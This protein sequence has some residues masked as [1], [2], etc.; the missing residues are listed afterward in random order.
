MIDAQLDDSKAC[1]RHCLSHDISASGVRLHADH[2]Y[3]RGSKVLLTLESRQNGW[4]QITSYTGSVVWAK[5]EA[6]DTR[7]ELGIHFIDS[8]DAEL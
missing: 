8:D 3:E 1:S 7:C 5:L 6:S 2:C 4:T